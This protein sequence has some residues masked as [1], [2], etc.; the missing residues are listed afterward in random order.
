MGSNEIIKEA[1]NLKLQERYLMIET[2]VK[3]L[4]NPDEEI[5]QSWIEESQKRLSSYKEGKLKTLSYEETF[6]S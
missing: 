3:S 5:E 6:D 1:I 2:L 4:N